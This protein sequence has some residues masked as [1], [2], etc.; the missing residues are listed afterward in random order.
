MTTASLEAPVGAAP[1][2]GGPRT[3][4]RIRLRL[5][6]VLAA[7]AALIIAGFAA[8]Q[9]T[10]GAVAG[11]AG[12]AA[13][14]AIAA[15]VWLIRR[16]ARIAGPRQAMAAISLSMLVAMLFFAGLAVATALVEKRAAPGV[17]LGALGIY[18]A[19]TFCEALG[20]SHA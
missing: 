20:A 9:G 11:G 19:F 2:T 5:A 18:L 4:A 10:I 8:A 6:A 1:E 13:G 16:R 12:V 15:V 3:A 17:L 7:T 14:C